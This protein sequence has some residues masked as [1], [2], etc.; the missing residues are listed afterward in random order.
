M[1]VFLLAGGV[2]IGLK[3]RLTRVSRNLRQADVAEMANVG[4][5][6]ISRIEH[7]KYVPP[8]R[9]RRILDALGIE[10]ENA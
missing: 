1:P 3:V 10:E 9:R 2:D 6:D 5:T 4:Q 8:S 7:S